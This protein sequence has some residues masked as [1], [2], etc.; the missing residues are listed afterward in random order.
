MYD[1]VLGFNYGI[2]F[3]LHGVFLTSLICFAEITK[4][5]IILI[6]ARVIK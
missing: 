2:S 6:Y 5:V 4:V 1:F 3:L